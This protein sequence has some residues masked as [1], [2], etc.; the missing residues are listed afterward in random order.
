MSAKQ[1]VFIQSSYQQGRADAASGAALPVR[2]IGTDDLRDAVARGWAD[3]KAKPSH[4]VVLAVIYPLAGVFLAQLTVSYDIF[5]L[6]FPL[7]AGFALIG[8][9]AA[10]GLY[11]ISRR[12]EKG[13]DSSWLHAFNVRKSPSIGPIL[14]LG[15]ILTGLFMAWLAVAYLIYYWTFGGVVPTS[16]TGFASDVLKTPRGW[17]LILLG[18]GVGLIF[19]IAALMITAVSFPLLLDRKVSLATAMRTSVS[20]VKASPVTMMTWGLFIA[21]ALVAGSLPLFVGL[22][23]VMPVLAHATWHLYRKVVV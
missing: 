18:N 3:F 12:R 6:L 21:A 9:F 11:E 14:G 1:N 20:A 23:V 15:A 2:P 4:L 5:P 17:A 13:L 16:I 10:L 8:P 19:A 22:S 7:M